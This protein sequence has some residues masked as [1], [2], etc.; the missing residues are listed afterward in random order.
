M[1][2][3]VC[4]HVC[5]CLRILHAVTCTYEY[6]YLYRGADG[7][8]LKGPFDLEV[9]FL[10]FVCVLFSL[11]PKIFTSMHRKRSTT[12]SARAAWNTCPMLRPR[13]LATGMRARER[14]YPSVYYMYVVCVCMCV[15][16]CVCVCQCVIYIHTY[17]MCVYVCVY[18]C[19]KCFLCP[20]CSA[21][22]QTICVP[23]EDAN[24]IYMFGCGHCKWE[25]CVC[26]Y[27][28][29]AECLAERKLSK[30]IQNACYEMLTTVR[31]Y[32]ALV[33]SL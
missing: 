2:M 14:V 4:V 10:I 17:Y 8:R 7:A 22:L 6:I 5:V 11:F 9:V 27:T 19:A 25:R 18:R 13:S 1:C 15:C 29:S 28:C 32:S 31:N 20:I 12:S 3:R 21:L 24:N 33:E 30:N 23:G 16:V 26:A